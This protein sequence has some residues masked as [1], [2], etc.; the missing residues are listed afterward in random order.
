MHQRATDHDAPGFARGHFR[1]EAIGEMGCFQLFEDL[2]RFIDHGGGHF[3]IRP[4]ADTAEE[5]GK[6]RLAP[7]D[8]RVQVL[9]RSFETSPSSGR[10]SKTFQR[11]RPRMLMDD[12]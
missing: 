12:S 6:D 1:N 2:I 11:S 9:M 3:M 5:S 4:Y 10:S 8:S 7:G